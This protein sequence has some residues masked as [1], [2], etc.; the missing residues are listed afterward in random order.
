MAAFA[1]EMPCFPGGDCVGCSVILATNA[2]DLIL[3]RR[4]TTE[5]W[6]P[7]PAPPAHLLVVLAMV[8]LCSLYRFT[9]TLLGLVDALEIKLNVFY[10][11]TS[12]FHI[13]LNTSGENWGVF[14][15]KI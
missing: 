4:F 12:L 8:A 2:P 15:W 11:K 6:K 7:W 3:G 5:Q 1:G 10:I 13:T 9:D 14:V